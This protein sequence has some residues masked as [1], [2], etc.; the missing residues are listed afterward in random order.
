MNCKRESKDVAANANR[1]VLQTSSFQQRGSFIT[2]M[3][4]HNKMNLKLYELVIKLSG[5]L[6]LV[7]TF[8]EVKRQ[9][10][11]SKKT[12]ANHLATYCPTERMRCWETAWDS[13]PMSWAIFIRKSFRFIRL[14]VN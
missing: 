7:G 12:D 2:A 8:L 4:S 9:E 13:V 3:M 11:V 6:T 5:S 1:K 14:H 10:I